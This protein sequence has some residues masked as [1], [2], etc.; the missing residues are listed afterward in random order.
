MITE[1][2]QGAKN[3][4]TSLEDRKIFSPILSSISDKVKNLK[5]QSL[6]PI[7]KT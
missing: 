5:T 7:N 4:E 2:S 6:I 1:Q 3:I